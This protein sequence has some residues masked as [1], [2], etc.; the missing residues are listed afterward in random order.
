MIA[1]SACHKRRGGGEGRVVARLVRAP[2]VVQAR[3]AMA[4]VAVDLGRRRWGRGVR[5]RGCACSLALPYGLV[6]LCGVRSVMGNSVGL[7]NVA[8]DEEKISLL[9]PASCI[10]RCSATVETVMFW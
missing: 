9:T 3:E 6:G 2:M 10:A 7:P 1:C 4:A 8:H 5:R